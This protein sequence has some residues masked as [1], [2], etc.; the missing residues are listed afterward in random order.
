MRLLALVWLLLPAL[1]ACQSLVL[2]GGSLGN[3]E[4]LWE[5]VIELAV[6]KKSVV[7]FSLT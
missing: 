5:K 3:D 6:S 7:I 4:T 2:F 1:A